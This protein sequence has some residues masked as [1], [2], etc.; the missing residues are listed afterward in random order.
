MHA[1]YSP[2]CSGK[3]QRAQNEAFALRLLIAQR[4]LYSRAKAWQGARWIGLLILGI[5]APF[6]TL[7]MPTAAVAIGAITGVWLFAGRTIIAWR[8]ARIMV[9]AAAIQEA[10]DQH[11]FDMPA[12]IVR[13]ERPE[14]EEIILL[15]GNDDD[16]QRVAKKENLFDWYPIDPSSDGSVSVAIAQRINASYTG[17]LIRT[18]V[19][20]WA[21]VSLAWLIALVTW[22]ALLEISL[23]NFLLGVLF[24]LLPAVL[25]VVEYV[26]STWKAAKDRTDLAATITRR[27]SP[28]DD[29]IDGQEL[30]VWQERLFDLR[31]TTPQIP[32]WLYG[33]TRRRNEAAMHTAAHQLRQTDH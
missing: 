11:L 33:L 32:N 6:V 12:T 4:R 31:R 29:K 7:L 25:D 28:G 16:L 17:R 15:S 24:P 1:N 13:S 21:V 5:G 30:L 20:I 23:T 8:E 2:P 9:R 26:I 27:L 18:T 22:A 10:F 19:K 14:P 3:I